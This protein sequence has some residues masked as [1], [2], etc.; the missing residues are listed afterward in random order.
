MAE[1]LNS[2]KNEHSSK[3]LFGLSPRNVTYRSQLVAF[4]YFVTA[5]LLLLAQIIFGLFLAAQYVWPT[6]LINSLPFNINRETHLNL[7]ILWLLLGLMGAT[8]YLIP[9]EA[10]SKLFSVKLAVLQWILLLIAAVGT[11][12]SF[13]FFRSDIGSLGKPFTESP[14]PWPYFIALGAVIFLVNI[15]VTL[16]RARRWTPI[17]GILFAGM[18]GISI[19]YMID[20]IFFPNLTIDFYW[21]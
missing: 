16:I 21:W 13:W 2:P 4:P 17:S 8:Y 3:R 19:L 18:A 6:F 9:E 15:G 10:R 1:N 12:I 20:M 5:G 14:Y 11:L 7:L